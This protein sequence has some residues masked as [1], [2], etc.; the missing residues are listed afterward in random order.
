MAELT[1]PR[2]WTKAGAELWKNARDTKLTT[3]AIEKNHNR[4]RG[5]TN[6]IEAVD[7]SSSQTLEK[8]TLA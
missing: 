3:A 7:T 5:Q 2:Q 6:T 1:R 8:C 4:S